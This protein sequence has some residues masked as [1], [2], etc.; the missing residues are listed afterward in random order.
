MTVQN[1]TTMADKELS[2]Y[3]IIKNLI[4][5]KINADRPKTRLLV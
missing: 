4:D 1:L 2:R 5:G 3:D